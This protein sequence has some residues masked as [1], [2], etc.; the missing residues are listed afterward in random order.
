MQQ[1]ISA[2]RAP[3]LS[4]RAACQS[5][6]GRLRR[7][8]EDRVVYVVPHSSDPLADRGALIVLADGMGG[9]AAGEVASKI[10]VETIP[11]VYYDHHV[12]AAEALALALRCANRAIFEH[13]RKA[14]D[15]RGMGTTATVV[16]IRENHAHIAHV[17]DSRCYLFRDGQ[18]CQLTDDHSLVMDLVRRGV[19]SAEDARHHPR[20]NIILKALGTNAR[21][22]VDV[23]DPLALAC[24]DVL[25]LCSD[26]LTDLVP[27]ASIAA[28]LDGAPP[29]T[30]CEALVTAANASGGSDNIT[31]AV[32]NVSRASEPGTGPVSV[33]RTSSR[34]TETETAFLD[35]AGAVSRASSP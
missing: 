15:L 12:P 33:T 4:I 10:A 19:I 14:P 31:V 35:P 1:L 7:L 21:I 17:G 16:A 18:L 25:L 32:F 20:R 23:L 5:D 8:N 3:A 11:A 13:G 29:R 2:L 27:D 6:T 9:A 26:G 24:G 30:A 34:T 28:I 22:E